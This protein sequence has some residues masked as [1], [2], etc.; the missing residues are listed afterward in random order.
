MT[1]GGKLGCNVNGWFF[2]MFLVERTE[3]EIQ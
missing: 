3:V 2:N 1:I